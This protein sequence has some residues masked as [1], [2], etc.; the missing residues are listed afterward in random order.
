MKIHRVAVAVL[1]A[2]LFIWGAHASEG[3]LDSRLTKIEKRLQNIEQLLIELK[4]SR[5]ASIDK[6]K[7]LPESFGKQE[8]EKTFSEFRQHY[9]TDNTQGL[10]DMM[11]PFARFQITINKF[12]EV[13]RKLRS[14][15]GDVE[16]G[17]FTHYQYDQ[18]NP[19]GEFWK[20]FYIIKTE[21]RKPATSTMYF[22]IRE[23]Q[24]RVELVG[25]N[26]NIN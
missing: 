1:L 2:F 23:I 25:F 21:K 18:K 10:F 11:S 24:G 8:I 17:I 12:T 22:N 3:S 7:P 6:S 19:V 14:I 16:S 26:L 15:T 9:N 5:T 4:E 13:I 20:I